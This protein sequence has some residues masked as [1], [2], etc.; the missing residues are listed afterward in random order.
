MKILLTGGSTGGHFYPLIAVAESLYDRALQKKIIKPEIWYMDS[1]KYNPRALF[2]NDIQFVEIPAGK[3]RRYF[4]FLNFTDLFKTAIGIV[5]ALI[6]MWKLYP[7][8]VFG[9]GGYSS[10]PALVAA[11]F[12]GIPIVIHESDSRPGRVNAWAGKFAKRIAVSYPDAAEYFDSSKVAYT[13]NPIRREIRIPLNEGSHEQLGID[14]G[15]PTLLIL[16]GSQGSQLIND[17]VLDSLPVLLEKYNIIHQTGRK[18]FAEVTRTAGV[19]LTNNKNSNRYKPLDYLN[20]LTIRLTS[21]A[22]DLIVSRAGSTIFEIAA[23]KKPSIV[24]PISPAVSH[25]QTKNAFSYAR[26]GACKV[27]EEHNL[28]THVFIAEVE[29]LMSNRVERQQL[30]DNAGKFARLD[31]G[32]KIADVLLEIALEHEK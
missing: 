5:L 18:N 7:D 4:S 6:N 31:S 17:V 32:D 11:R 9:K 21:G 12:F 15:I 23:W 28:T 22:A 20:D 8:V 19:I 26:A 3:L 13:G 24:I 25:D 1:S 29:N 27:I 16:G 10:F 30:A 14:K 2:D